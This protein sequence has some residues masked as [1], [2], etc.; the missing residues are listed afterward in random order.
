L[1]YEA[2]KQDWA[3]RN[4]GYVKTVLKETG[5]VEKLLETSKH[6]DA[7]KYLSVANTLELSDDELPTF[8]ARLYENDLEDEEELPEIAPQDLYRMLHVF[9]S[10]YKKMEQS[11]GI[12]WDKIHN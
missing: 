11:G 2:R 10:G 1:N 4:L 12:P 3:W 8:N 7:S 5:Q 6:V 9:L